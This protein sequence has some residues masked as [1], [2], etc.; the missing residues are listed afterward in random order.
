MRQQNGQ[1]EA[2]GLRLDLGGRD[3]EAAGIEAAAP[4][5][6]TFH[7][8]YTIFRRPVSTS[9]DGDPASDL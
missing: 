9:T 4:G 6:R 5:L 8:F 7:V 2:L 1:R 3:D